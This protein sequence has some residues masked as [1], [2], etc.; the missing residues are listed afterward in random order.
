MTIVSRL[1]V[2]L[3]MALTLA[4]AVRAQVATEAEAEAAT[5]AATS[6][7]EDTFAARL[8]A[9]RAASAAQDAAREW[10]VPLDV[11]LPDGER[12]VWL[13]LPSETA[14]RPWPIVLAFHGGGG[15]A[16]Q[17]AASSRLGE[18]GVARG[19]LVVFP[20]GTSLLGFRTWNGGGGCCG[21]A[22]RK[23]V[24]DVAF[25]GELLDTLAAR[26]EVDSGRVL[27]TGMSNGAVMSFRLGVELSERI[28][29]IAPVAGS[30]MVDGLPARPVSV[31]A[32]HGALDENVPVAGGVGNG[33][34]EVTWRSQADSLAPFLERAELVLDEEPELVDGDFALH[35]GRGPYRKADV[36]HVRLADHGHAWPGT[37]LRPAWDSA[38]PL[39]DDLDA[40]SFALDWFAALP[41]REP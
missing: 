18:A 32:I 5:E 7:S 36:R 20:E 37:P 17:F 38:E 21:A 10:L 39:G 16:V 30:C 11:T 6:A 24:D 8:R 22:A 31:L 15:D 14:P 41:A 29:A 2:L 34:A 9:R 35:V 40:S 25:T 33:L 27:A 28:L 12:R 4:P 1:S 26:F 13:A 19:M 3:A 23:E